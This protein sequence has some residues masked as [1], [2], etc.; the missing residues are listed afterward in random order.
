MKDNQAKFSHFL[1]LVEAWSVTNFKLRSVSG[2]ASLDWI[3]FLCK[4]TN[5]ADIVQEIIE[6]IEAETEGTSQDGTN[7]LKM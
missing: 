5:M 2:G 4:P 7:G 1:A 3:S 6:P